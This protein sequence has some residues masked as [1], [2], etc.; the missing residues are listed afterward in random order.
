MAAAFPSA[1]GKTNLA[2]VVSPP[3][4]PGWRVWTVGD[5]IAWMR[6]GEDGRLYAINPEAG[7]FGVAPGT[8]LK[9]NPNA[10]ATLRSNSIFTNVGLT[11]DNEPWWEGMSPPPPH[12]IDWRGNSWQPGGTE[13][14]A[15]PNARFTAPARQCPGI[16]K[17][18]EK[19]TGVP[20]SAIIFGGRRAR[21]A[22]LVFEAFDWNHG[23]YVGAAVASETTAAAQ[24][25]QLGVIRRDPFAMLPFCGYNMADYFAH[26]LRIGAVPG[27]KLPKIFHVN[28]FRQDAD[29]KYIWPGFGENV[30]VLRWIL[31]RCR[32]EV[33][34]VATP[35]GNVPA[36]GSLD[37]SGIEN[38]VSPE[39]LEGLL[40]IDG[41]DWQN[42]I[43]DQRHFFEKFGERLP[44]EIR[45][46]YIATAQRLGFAG[47]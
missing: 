11:D 41:A 45:R 20:I 40:H 32:G 14:A 8:S 1:C 42:E 23:V 15:H 24:G 9:T 28:W 29:K 36:P 37:L 31:G 44:D 21:T 27:R 12:L 3:S 10:M 34:A 43:A 6:F 5:D 35:I 38:Q 39:T 26:W 16:S 22:P 47:C 2:M 25:Q 33:D 13:K 18:W 4:Q 30:R 19:P 17:E 7:F 46:Q